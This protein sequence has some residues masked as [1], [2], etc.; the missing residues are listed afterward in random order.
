MYTWL[1]HYIRSSLSAPK[2]HSHFF[3]TNSPVTSL[4]VFL[5]FAFGVDEKCKN[6]S[7]SIQELGQRREYMKRDVLSCVFVCLCLCV[8]TPRPIS[9]R[10]SSSQ[11]RVHTNTHIP[12]KTGDETDQQCS[13]NNK[14]RDIYFVES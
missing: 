12:L 2:I 6:D 4:L 8:R 7:K 13:S 10:N 9:E 5:L 14:K 1:F 11:I 3:R